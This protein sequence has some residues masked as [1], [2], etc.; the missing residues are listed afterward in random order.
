MGTTNEVT[1]KM[2][3]HF[4]RRGMLMN[5]GTLMVLK[6][7]LTV[8]LGALGLGA[9]A[10]GTALGQIKPGDGNVPA[11]NI[12]DDQIT[13][14]NNVPANP[15]RPSV[16]PEGAM[17]SPL[18]TAIGTGTTAVTDTGTLG[19]GYVI[20]PGGSNCGVG[21]A[22]TAF[23]AVGQGS[24]ATDV[25]EG[26][27]SLM[28]K[29]TDVYGDP[30]DLTSTGTA[31]ALQDAEKALNDAIELGQTGGALTSLRD[32]VAR[33]QTAHGNAVAAFTDA[34]GGPIYQAGVAEWMAQAAVTKS[35][36]DYNGLVVDTKTALD[37][38]DAMDYG[39]YR[40]L[41]AT[42]NLLVGTVV[43]IVDGMGTV[44]LTALTDYING[45]L[46]NPQ[47]ATVSEEGV[48]TTVDSNFDAA[49]R[50][51][52]P[53]SLQDHDNDSATDDILLG[54]VSTVL[55][56]VDEIRKLSDDHRIAAAALK[57]LRD[58]NLNPALQLTFDEA[59][60]RAQLEADYY[61]GVYSGMLADST[62]QNPITVDDPATPE[63]DAAPYSIF[64]RNGAYLQESNKRLVQETGLR[65]AVAAR[66]GAT[67]LVQSQFTTPQSF[68]EQL[69]ARRQALK[70]TADRA[71]ANAAAAGGT[72]P[73]N[74]ADAATAAAEAL[75]AAE[76]AQANIAGLYDDEDDPTKALVEELLKT[77]GDDGQALVDAI[78]GTYEVAKGAADAAREVVD[79]LTGEG[80]AVSTNTANIESLDGRVTVNE[81]AISTNA[82]NI[83]MNAENIVANRTDI[84]MNMANIATN[85]GDIMTNAGN[86]MDN[87]GMIDTNAMGISSN[88]GRIDAAE[89]MIGQNQ[90]NISG[91]TAM[92]GE[93]SESL[94]VVRAGVAASMALAGMPSINGRG[95]AI[96]VGSF[97][98]ESAFAIGFQIQSESTSFK[99]G[100]TSGGGATGASA[101]VGFQF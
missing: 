50:L 88:S 89:T 99:V 30:V 58:D 47:V 31:G 87:R 82:D 4:S 52:V 75:A 32:A 12:F 100:V 43:T 3:T 48:T 91:N 6:R 55:N 74:V 23:D 73:E 71:V 19:L 11:P 94:E 22:G 27:S 66:E 85:A 40:P 92:I 77:G 7:L 20:P 86:I 2:A 44:A 72:I 83:T 90:R 76:M 97:D 5:R 69:V 59:Y 42:G 38:L 46:T 28:G 56:G 13:C 98:G 65:A 37:T 35:I 53:M 68:Y 8:A 33:A 34:S 41:G 39:D 60:R 24:I 62:N 61:E 29:F 93:L 101:G 15:P 26:Y 95:I 25:A 79:E 70:V 81:G 1:F 96:G 16:V 10:A 67:A 84:D 54:I 78:A 14:I 49:G 80:G 63:N 9:L 21:A 18:D 17:V 36:A 51:V 45:D 64:S 57:E